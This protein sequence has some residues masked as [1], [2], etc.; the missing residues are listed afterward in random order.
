MLVDTL[1]NRGD[2]SAQPLYAFIGIAF[3]EFPPLETV[4]SDIRSINP[5]SYSSLNE[6]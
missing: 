4:D 3:F 1:V 6:D 2:V 5:K